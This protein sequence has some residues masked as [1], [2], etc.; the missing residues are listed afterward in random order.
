MSADD[1]P[2]MRLHRGDYLRVTLGWPPIARLIYLE[3]LGAQWDNGALPADPE[4]MRSIVPG[5]TDADWSAAWPRVESHFPVDGE[6]RRNPDLAADRQRTK[7]MIDSRRR[8]G[9]MT[10]TKRWGVGAKG[11]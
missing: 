7:Q 3:L 9:R 8:G 6:V 2:I 4:R 10:A 11:R 5:I 1:L